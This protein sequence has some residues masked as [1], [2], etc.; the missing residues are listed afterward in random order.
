MT[1]PMYDA[2]V[3]GGGQAGLASAYCL[4][5]EGFR[6][7]VLEAAERAVGSWPN[8][9]DSLTLFSPAAYSSLPGFPFPG[10]PERYPTRDEVVAYLSAYRERFRFP[11][12]TG[13]RVVDVRR[14]GDGFLVRTEGGGRYA[15]RNVISATGAFHTPHMPDIPGLDAYGGRVLHS[16]AY[17]SPEGYEGKRVVVVGAGNSAVQ[18][19]VELATTASVTIASR[20]P[21]RF[22]PQRIFGKD[23]H[24]WANA[25][26]FDRLPIG[27]WLRRPPG[28]DVLD[29][30]EYRSALERNEPGRR[31]MFVRFTPRGV[32]WS[33]GTEEDVDVVIFATGFRHNAEYLRNL[34]ALDEQGTPIQSNGA[35][36]TV[37]GLFF[38]GI[39]WQRSHASATIRGV[40]ADAKYAIARLRGGASGRRRGAADGR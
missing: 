25:V 37:E 18:I 29:S 21:V 10:D 12:A 34:G 28:T 4:Q 31:E 5:Q 3:I 24:F 15:A 7:L 17:V 22:L 14:Q 38:V 20:S 26:G 13:E 39:P 9:Y 6:F 36:K 1:T 8:Y 33:D 32:V 19:A 2:V 27:R 16:K 35:S 23:V 40:G 30:G 11:I